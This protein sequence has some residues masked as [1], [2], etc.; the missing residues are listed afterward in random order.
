MLDPKPRRR[1]YWFVLFLLALLGI[2]GRITGLSF[3]PMLVGVLVYLVWNLYCLW[4][5][6]GWL[7]KT[8]KKLPNGVPGIW[9][10]VFYRLEVRRR[11][12]A[13]R[14]RRIA[15][16]LK[17]FRASTSA[18][19]DATIVLDR[20][21]LIQW[22]NDAA[23][24][25]LGVR[26]TDAGQSVTNLIRSEEFR[27]YLQ[28]GDYA[29]ALNLEGQIFPEQR[30]VLRIIPYEGNRYLLQARDV[31]EQHKVELIRRDFVANASHE[32]RTP[33]SVLQGSIE[34]MEQAAADQPALGKSLMRMRRQ[35]ERMMRILEDL[36]ILARLESGRDRLGQPVLLSGLV[37]E[38]G[39]EARVAS[40]QAGGHDLRVEV[41]PEICLRGRHEDLHAAIYNLVM[42]A[43]RYTPAGGRIRITLRRDKAGLVFGVADTG[44][45]IL[46]QHLPRLTE[47]FYRVDVG[48]SRAAGGTGLGLAIVRHVLDNYHAR[49]EISSTP[50]KG[51]V[52]RFRIGSEFLCT[53]GP[54]ALNGQV[55]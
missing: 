49:L 4:R 48:R 46:P 14:K 31:T 15:H 34:Q 40:E 28:H 25:I 22:L 47:R 50:G 13:S 39:E 2:I 24:E 52:F 53:P 27:E 18:L 6:A 38:I 3:W 19:P 42:N 26:K 36:L 54:R 1:E 5:L 16:L 35:S 45:G 44:A 7:D 30:L 41:E 11:K 21:F 23:T 9:G 8:R 12:S 43:I 33:L 17:G 51:S 37:G 32:L 29:G 20:E 10:Y 55:L